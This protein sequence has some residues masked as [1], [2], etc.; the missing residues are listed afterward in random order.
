[1]PTAVHVRVPATSANLGPGFD[2]LGLA[3]TLYD[4]VEVELADSGLWIDVTGE[5]EETA[6]RGEQHLIVKTF[7]ET[8]AAIGPA[9]EPGLRVRCVNRIPH[10]R[11]LGSSSAATVAGILAARALHPEGAGLTDADVLALATRIEGHPDNVAP[12]LAGGLTIAWETT[13]GPRTTRLD[14]VPGVRPVAFVPEHRLATERARGLLPDV[15]P[16][17]DA[18][19]NSGRA[20]LLIAALTARPEL[21]LDATEDRLHQAYRA[22]AMPESVA[23]VDRLR[24]RGV[25]AVVSGAG[26]TVLA[27][28]SAGEVD[29]IASEVGTSWHIHPLNVDPHGAC[30]QPI[31]QETRVSGE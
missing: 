31:N 5:G 7:R 20:A 3:L 25:P 15:V 13:A 27:L 12:C 8:Y 21:L 18:A 30:V 2:A 19:A 1:M 9:P 23:L 16:H 28:V 4:D 6:R 17:A 26:P 24:A 22:P 29:S 10:A 11:G 14:V